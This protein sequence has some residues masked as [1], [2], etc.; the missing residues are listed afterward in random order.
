M[1]VEAMLGLSLLV[2]GLGSGLAGV[3]DVARAQGETS[4]KVVRPPAT[5]PLTSFYDTPR[6][7]PPGK[8]GELIRSEPSDEYSLPPEI[9][10]RRISYHSRSANGQDVAVSA[11][12]L[13][14]DGKPPAGGWPVIAWA[15][16]FRGVARTCAP[17]LLKNLGVGPILAMYANLGYAVVATDYSGLG[18]DSGK[19]VIDMESNALDLMSS[20]PAARAA[21]KEIG[22]KWIAVGPFQG[23]LTAVGVAES[24]VPDPG[25]LGSVVTSGLAD[26]GPAYQRFAER[27]SNRMLL[28]MAATVKALYPGFEPGDI[29]TDKALPAYSQAGQTCGG[30]TGQE[31]AG[32]LLKAG[33]ERNSYVKD[34]F[35]RNAPGQKPARG[36]LLVISGERDPVIP[37][38]MSA[39]TVAKMCKQGGR[40]LFLK[41]PDADASA[42]AGSSTSDQISWI[43]ARFAGLQAPSNCR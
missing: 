18:S 25:Y 33:W 26:A 2:S 11:V 13:V 30:E 21:V 34:F 10:V 24:E 17:S 4:A 14:P 43:K 35:T 8:P 23:G 41:Y 42:V 29:L 27:S 12:V 9:S 31:F 7:L 38:E 40:V 16:G 36:P 20:L 15:H 5:L 37:T 3:T 19:A 6:P 22:S 1:L 32:G 28:A 39:Q